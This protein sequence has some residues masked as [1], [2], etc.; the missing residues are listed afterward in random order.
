[1]NSYL[2]DLIVFLVGCFRVKLPAFVN[3]LTNIH[4][5]TGMELGTSSVI[6][7]YNAK[8]KEVTPSSHIPPPI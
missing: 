4:N 5:S 2:S 7:E 3:A 1:M 8:Y 6:K